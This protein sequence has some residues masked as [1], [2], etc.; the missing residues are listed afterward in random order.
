MPRRSARP[1]RP[2][3][4][5]PGVESHW[6]PLT[7]CESCSLPRSHCRAPRRCHQRARLVHTEEVT[8]RRVSSEGGRAALLP[9]TFPRTILWAKRDLHS[10]PVPNPCATVRALRQ[11]TV[12]TG[13]NGQHVP[14]LRRRERRCESCRGAL[15]HHQPNRRLTAARRSPTVW[16]RPGLTGQVRLPRAKYVRVSDS[17]V[18]LR[19]QAPGVSCVLAACVRLQALHGSMRPARIA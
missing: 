7:D 14:A 3:R 11:Q 1:S 4:P 5:S 16:R 18:Q 2:S 8:A 15:I 10:V 9:T 13:E 12:L 17:T 6:P 19:A